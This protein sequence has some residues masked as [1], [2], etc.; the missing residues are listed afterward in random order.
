MSKITKIIIAILI[1]VFSVLSIKIAVAFSRT[2][3]RLCRD[4]RVKF[5]GVECL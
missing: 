5:T 2:L 4:I 1:V 3:G